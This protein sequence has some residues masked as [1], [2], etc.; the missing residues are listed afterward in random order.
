MVKKVNFILSQD[1]IPSLHE[2]WS[3]PCSGTTFASVLISEWVKD[4]F[5]VEIAGKIKV[6]DLVKNTNIY[7]GVNSLLNSDITAEANN[8]LWLHNPEKLDPAVNK[9]KFINHVVCVSFNH[10]LR[11]IK[12][13]TSYIYFLINKIR[14]IY[15]PFLLPDIDRKCDKYDNKKNSISKIA[16]IG[17]TSKEKGFHNACKIASKLI[18]EKRVS[19]F[20][21]YGGKF[22][23]SNNKNDKIEFPPDSFENKCIKEYFK[24]K[25]DLVFL[26]G[27]VSRNHLFSEIDFYEAILVGSGGNETFCY[28]ALEAAVKNVKIFTPKKGGQYEVLKKLGYQNV[29]FYK[30][31]SDAKKKMVQF[32]DKEIKSNTLSENIFSKAE[33]IKQWLKIL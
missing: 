23:Y 3:T 14:Y 5:V 7:V 9:L 19:E 18:F 4:Y 24:E 17:N 26:K 21:V 15:N 20:H 16:Y 2:L 22:I 29:L 33:L 8:I 13:N 10:M 27:S 11:Q 30:D 32:L 25:E 1:K 12:I 6:K 31:V 28:S